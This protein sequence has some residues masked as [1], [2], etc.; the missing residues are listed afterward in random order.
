MLAWLP[1]NVSTFGGD[2]DGIFAFVYYIVGAW[3]IAT[4]AL[5]L[6]FLIRYRRRKG[7]R[8]VYA[9]GNSLSQAAW[10]LIPLVLVLF[11]DL[12][13]DFRSADVW[14]RIKLSNPP[15]DVQVVVTGKQFNWIMTYPGPDG[16]FGT[17]DDKTL[18]NTLIV[19]VNKVVRLTLKSEDVIHSFFLPHLRLKQDVVPGREITAWFQATRPGRWEIPCAELCGFGHGGM[20]GWLEVRSE[21]DYAA[22]LRKEWPSS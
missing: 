16:R 22:W 18:D 19:P 6:I 13:I 20:K 3:F 11:L 9:P 8:A 15:A 7:R 14:A 1:E 5:I 17:K 10:I 4:Q 12:W 21:A 2:I